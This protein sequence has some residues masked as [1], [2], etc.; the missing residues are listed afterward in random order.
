MYPAVQEHEIGINELFIVRYHY[1][2]Q[3]S[4]DAHVDGSEFSFIIAL[5]KKSEYI[6][7]GTYFVE[8]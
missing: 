2:E 3:R 7:G 8:N 5:N 4:L 1:L 6:Q